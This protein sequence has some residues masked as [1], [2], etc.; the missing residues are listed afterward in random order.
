MI[1]FFVIN[2]YSGRPLRA[3]KWDD[4]SDFMVHGERFDLPFA[5]PGKSK[6]RWRVSHIRTVRA[7]SFAM[8]LRFGLAC[9]IARA[10]DASGDYWGQVSNDETD[11]K[12]LVGWGE[13]RQLEGFDCLD[14]AIQPFIPRL[15]AAALAELEDSRREAR[16]RR[17]AVAA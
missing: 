12:K 17:G 4:L 16:A 10:F 5:D 6:A 9:D 7:V 8:G 3:Y 11:P 14:A 1:Q 13:D 2:P 15:P